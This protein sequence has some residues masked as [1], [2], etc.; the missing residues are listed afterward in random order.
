MLEIKG[1]SRDDGNNGD[2]LGGWRRLF[3]GGREAMKVRFVN[4]QDFNYLKLIPETQIEADFMRNK[5]GVDPENEYG[6]SA[7][8]S[9]D[10]DGTFYIDVDCIS[11][12]QPPKK[13]D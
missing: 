7:H 3:N 2:S 1:G 10:A 8:V 11:I 6:G 9:I 5:V 12:N 13:E 4:I